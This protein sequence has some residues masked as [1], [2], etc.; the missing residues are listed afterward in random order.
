MKFEK[1]RQETDIREFIHHLT[2]ERNL[3]DNTIKAYYSDLSGLM[4][5]MEMDHKEE[6]NSAALSGY[7]FHLQME[8]KMAARS[9]RRKYVSIQ[10]YC[11]FLNQ[12]YSTGE[13]FLNFSSRRFQLPKTLPKTLTN[14][15]IK[16]LIS[17]V[18]EEYQ[19]ASS[20]H[21]RKLCIRNMCIIELLF[22][23]GLRVGEI[24]A[25]NLEDYRQDEH[26]VLIHG[27]GNKERILYI[28][29]PA[30][31]QKMDRWLS[32]RAESQAD[33]SAVFISRRGTRLSIYSIENVFYK[34]RNRARINPSATPHY[35]RHSFATQLLNNGAGIRDV[36]ELLGHSSLMTTQI[37]TEVSMSRK[38]EVMMKYNGRNRIEV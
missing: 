14:E 5:W 37:Y 24:S 2:L 25:M 22:C 21:A 7:F 26:A 10:Q 20:D 29:S 28:P 12:K 6:L 36:Q 23:L 32:L 9:I 38:I 27:K 13:R 31:I 17:S 3:S 16:R 33:S 4:N 8:R 11:V 1:T 19:E 30:V 18:N 15:E 35:L 34:Y